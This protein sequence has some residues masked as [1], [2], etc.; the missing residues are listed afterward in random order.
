M[1]RQ[2]AIL[3]LLSTLLLSALAGI[4][5]LVRVWAVSSPTRRPGSIPTTRAVRASRLA[6]ATS[7]PGTSSVAGSGL[8]AR[9]AYKP[10]LDLDTSGF[11]TAVMGVSRWG[12][13]A[14]LE[15]ISTA[16]QRVASEG[17]AQI[18]RQLA[19]PGQPQRETL[20]LLQKKAKLLHYQGEPAKAYDV[21]EQLRRG[22]ARDDGLAADLR[23][24]IIYYQGVTALRIGENQNCILCRGESS[25]ILPV[26]PEAVHTNPSG[27]R[28]AI[29]HFTEYLANFPDDLEVRCC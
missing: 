13:T 19:L 26:V 15:E 24:T 28:L 17:L 11:V 1:L 5:V 22:I 2:K 3:A 20:D 16:W 6:S 18:D 12:P 21:L 10:R 27:S 23:S 7:A 8:R 4:V 29:Q 14:S 9:P 25:C